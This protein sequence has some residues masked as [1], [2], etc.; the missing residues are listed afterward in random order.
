MILGFGPDQGST[1]TFTLT[2][3]DAKDQTLSQALPFVVQ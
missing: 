1:H 2:V 3:T